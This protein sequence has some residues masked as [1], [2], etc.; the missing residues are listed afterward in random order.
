RSAMEKGEQA[1]ALECAGK[2][3]E[4]TNQQTTEQTYV[5][6]FGVS[7]KRLRENIA[8]AKDK[9]RQLEQQI[10]IVKANEAVQK[11]QT[12]VSSTNVGANSKMTT[13]VESLE[14]I[15]N[16]QAEK[17][18]QL[19]AASEMQEEQSGS[20]LDKKL[21]AAGITSGGQ[22]SAEDELARILGK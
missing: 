6:Q 19:E 11:A 18:A 16:R 14:R 3:A 21:A 12:A 15:K 9:L 8:Q 7:E 2:V 5:D 17:Q 10:D 22:S 20:S 13:A 4:F 1:L